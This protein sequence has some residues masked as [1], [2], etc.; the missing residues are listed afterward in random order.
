MPRSKKGREIA[1]RWTKTTVAIGD[2]SDPPTRGEKRETV[3][4]LGRIG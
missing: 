4:N 2:N 3:N 1:G